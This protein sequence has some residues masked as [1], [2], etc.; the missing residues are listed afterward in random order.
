MRLNLICSSLSGNVTIFFDNNEISKIQRSERYTFIDLLA[1][2]GNM[3]GLFLGVS[4]LA[5]IELVYY[6]TLRLF[7]SLRQR[8]TST[9]AVEPFQTN[10]NDGNPNNSTKNALVRMKKVLKSN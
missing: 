9:V 6:F 5:I 3:L 1:I 4:A 8:K 10:E 2:C 7:W